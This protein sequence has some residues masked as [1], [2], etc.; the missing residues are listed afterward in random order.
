VG[1][2]IARNLLGLF[3]RTIYA[4]S[5]FFNISSVIFLCATRNKAYKKSLLILD[6]LVPVPHYIMRV[7]V[8]SSVKEERGLWSLPTW[9]DPPLPHAAARSIFKGK[10]YGLCDLETLTKNTVKKCKTVIFF[11][12]CTR[13]RN[14]LS[15]INQNINE[16][17]C[18]PNT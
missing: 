13:H 15:F 10:N 14:R 18:N 9:T 4:L 17:V 5:V 11:Q 16:K 1:S 12:R 7:I 2:S 6:T 3:A 8:Y